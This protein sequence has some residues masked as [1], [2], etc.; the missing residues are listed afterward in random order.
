M[1]DDE[2]NDLDPVSA[3][4]G[5]GNTNT[6]TTNTGFDEPTQSGLAY[7]VNTTP[8]QATVA[9]VPIA[10]VQQP[11]QAATRQTTQ[12]QV[13]QQDAQQPASQEGN[14]VSKIGEFI[15][16]DSALGVT[17]A[18]GVSLTAATLAHSTGG[19]LDMALTLGI[20]APTYWWI[21]EEFRDPGQNDITGRVMR[22]SMDSLK[23]SALAFAITESIPKLTETLGMLPSI[24]VAGIAGAAGMGY[25]L[26]RNRYDP[27]EKDKSL[28][29]SNAKNILGKIGAIANGAMYGSLA[30]YYA[31]VADMS[32]NL[33]LGDSLPGIIGKTYEMISPVAD[34]I[35][36][37]SGPILATALAFTGTVISS[38]LWHAGEPRR[39]KKTLET[40]AEEGNKTSR[41]LYSKNENNMFS[42]G[43]GGAMPR[44]LARLKNAIGGED[45]IEYAE[46]VTRDGKNIIELSIAP[47]RLKV[48][49]H[50]VEYKPRGRWKGL[51]QRTTVQGERGLEE[52]IDGNSEEEGVDRGHGANIID[53]II[54]NPN[55]KNEFPNEG[56]GI[57][58][59]ELLRHALQKDGYRTK[60]EQDRVI[61]SAVK[62]TFYEIK[63]GT[64]SDTY[65]EKAELVCE[66][67]FVKDQETITRKLTINMEVD[68]GKNRRNDKKEF[69]AYEVE[70]SITVDN[71]PIEYVTGGI[72]KGLAKAYGEIREDYNDTLRSEKL[73]IQ[74]PL[75]TKEEMMSL[76]TLVKQAEGTLVP[77][78]VNKQTKQDIEEAIEGTKPREIARSRKYIRG[79]AVIGGLIAGL[80]GGVELLKSDYDVTTIYLCDDGVRNEDDQECMGLMEINDNLNEGKTD[81]VDM[82]VINFDM[83]AENNFYSPITN[84]LEARNSVL[85]ASKTE[86]PDYSIA[87][88][89]IDSGKSTASKGTR[90]GRSIRRQLNGYED[91]V[92]HANKNPLFTYV[93]TP[94]DLVDGEMNAEIII[95][96]ITTKHQGN[97]N[98]VRM[99]ETEFKDALNE[100]NNGFN[101]LDD[102]PWYAKG[103]GYVVKLPIP[104]E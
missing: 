104:N 81:L 30:Y 5:M 97:G 25:G 3:L 26:F 59:S 82:G 14:L 94:E 41:C 84:Y 71:V 100:E 16:T 52:R 92:T 77:F 102:M 46:R 96:N 32:T 37:I 15:D 98:Y 54:N 42:I 57:F 58:I 87:L 89:K 2:N 65:E 90:N 75:S 68:G 27:E 95:G 101:N 74:V 36:D 72:K 48:E 38:T 79:A 60:E 49:G 93:V 10:Q 13:Q 9:Q 50:R 55:Q 69:S 78:F 83:T 56:K 4:F 76:G 51:Y 85:T 29:P 64:T 17:L 31:F 33:G 63:N 11:V 7:L 73:G 91:A 18:T 28:L 47:S 35:L 61:A 24:G 86:N 88:S 99:S 45:L 66:Y 19:W 1:A 34:P 53:Q 40:A 23:Y 12:Q 43:Y 80:A 21:T 39:K 67:S 22:G 44:K 62:G 103:A 6:S 70:M 8:Q 20:G